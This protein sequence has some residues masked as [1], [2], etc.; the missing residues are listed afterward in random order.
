MGNYFSSQNKKTKIRIV[1][2]KNEGYEIENG[3]L[4][5]KRDVNLKLVAFLNEDKIRQVFCFCSFIFFLY[6]SF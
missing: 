2:P 5:M 3:L 4:D 6:N 1:V